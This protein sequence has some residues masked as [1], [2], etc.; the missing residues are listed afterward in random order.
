MRGVILDLCAGELGGWS[1]PYIA[2]GYKVIHVD[3][4]TGGDARLW[5]SEMSDA[6][7]HP[8]RFGDIR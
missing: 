3:I 4:K 7:P 2:A 6:P 1:E 5:P 8:N